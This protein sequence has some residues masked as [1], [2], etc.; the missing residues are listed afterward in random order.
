VSP[1]CAADAGTRGTRQTFL[2]D[3]VFVPNL[4]GQMD[5]AQKEKWV[6]KALNYEI[7][8]CYAQTE[9][10]DR[11]IHAYTYVHSFICTYMLRRT[12]GLLV[13]GTHRH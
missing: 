5:D 10:R 3:G 8:G 12:H 2:H 1:P 9:V 6:N 13:G 4:L 7:L 11:L